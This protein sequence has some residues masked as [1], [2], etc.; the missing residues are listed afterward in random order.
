VVEVV[1]H[2]VVELVI[3]VGAVVEVVL[4]RGDYLQTLFDLAMFK[5]D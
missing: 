2:L 4:H 3:L 1:M 5:G